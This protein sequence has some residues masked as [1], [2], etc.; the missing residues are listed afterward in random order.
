L[1][2]SASVRCPG[3]SETNDVFSDAFGASDLVEVIIILPFFWDLKEQ[4]RLGL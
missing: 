3:G 1:G 2:V 4:D